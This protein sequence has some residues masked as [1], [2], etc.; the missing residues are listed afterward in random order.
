MEKNESQDGGTV[1]QR[2]NNA[3]VS[4]MMLQVPCLGWAPSILTGGGL[5]VTLGVV[6]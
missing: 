5:V 2:L 3:L 6:C 4:G 1:L